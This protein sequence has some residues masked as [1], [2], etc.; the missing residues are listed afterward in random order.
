MKVFVPRILTSL[1]ACMAAIQ[2]AQAQNDPGATPQSGVASVPE[3]TPNPPVFFNDAPGQAAVGN[4]FGYTEVQRVF[5]PL[6]RVDTRGG[7]LFGQTGFT[8]VSGFLPYFLD[9]DSLFF[10]DA[11]GFA[12]YNPSGGANVGFG[13][14]GYLE[15]FDRVVGLV[16]WYDFDAGHQRNYHQFAL[17]FESLG[18]YFD[19]RANGYLP[20]GTTSSTLQSAVAGP[21]FYYNNFILL[22]RLT[23]RET[24]YTG[25]DTEIGG[26]APV[27]GRYGLSAYA[28]FYFFNAGN[29]GSLTG[30]SAR[31]TGQINDSMTVGAQYTYDHVFQSNAQVQVTLTIPDGKPTRWLRQLRVRDRLTAPVIRNYRVVAHEDFIVRAEQAYNPADNQPFFVVHVDPNQNPGVGDGTFENPYSQLSQ[32]DTLA[33]GDKSNVDIVFV[34]PN[35][36]GSSTNLDQGVTLLSNQRLLSSAVPHIFTAIQGT[37]DLPGY[38]P[39]DLPPLLTNAGGGNVVTFADGA[40]NV[41]VSGFTIAGSA[42]GNG[43]FGNNNQGININRNTVQDG[44]NG[45]L[46]TNLSG[47][48]AAGFASIIDQNNFLNNIGDG[49]RVDNDAANP[50]E[51]VLSR[52]NAR[53]N[54]GN[55]FAFRSANGSSIGGI[56]SGNSTA[57]SD[58]TTQNPN[59]NNGLALFADGGTIDFGNLANGWQIGGTDNGSDADPLN[60]ANNFSDN[61]NFGVNVA[62]TN[63]STVSLTL[64]NNDVSRN[65]LNGFGIQADSGTASLIIGGSTAAD[66]NRFENNGLNGILIDLSGSALAA[67]SIQNNT[68]T[69]NGANGLGGGAGSGSSLYNIDVVFNGGLTPSQEA[70][71]ALAAAKWESIIVGDV[72][73]VGSIDDIRI[74]AEGTPIDGAGGILGQAGPT[75]LRPTTFLPYQG[76]MRFDTADL[77]SLEASGQLDEVIVHEMAHVIG[78]GSELIWQP[79]NLLTGAGG[80]DPR[81]IGA[82]AVREYNARFNTNDTGVPVENT[83]GTGTR[84]AHWRESI[85]DN[86]LMTGIL[87][88][89]VPNPISRVTVGQWQDLGY[90]VNYNAAEPYARTGLNSVTVP[91]GDVTRPTPVVGAAVVSTPH[92]NLVAVGAPIGDGIHITTA[93]SAT[94]SPST[95]SNNNVTQSARHGLYVQTADTSAISNLVVNNNQFLNNGTGTIGSG[96]FFQRQDASTFNATVTNNQMSQNLG[97][98]WSINVLGAAAPAMNVASADNTYDANFRHGTNFQADEDGVL[99]FTSSRDVYTG[100]INHFVNLS[101]VGDSVLNATFHNASISGGAN[102]NGTANGV[103]IFGGGTGVLNLTFDSPADPLFTGT[104]TA[105]NNNANGLVA[106]ITQNSKLNLNVFDTSIISNETDGVNIHREDASLVLASFTRTL[107]NGNGDNGLQFRAE[108]ADPS[109]PSQPSPGVPNRLFLTN[110]Q[111]NNNI[112]NGLEVATLVDASLVVNAK[113]TTFNNNGGVGVQ[114]VST[115]SSSFGNVAT[116]ERSVFNGVTIRGNGGDGMQLFAMGNNANK[117][118]IL[119]E[120]NATDGNTDISGNADDGIEATAPY[121]TVDLLVQG[122]TLALGYKTTI[123]RNTGNGIEMNVANIA[124]DGGDTA[125]INAFFPNQFE[126][127]SF[128]RFNGVGVLTVNNVVI[129]D[130]NSTDGIANGNGANG[131]SLFNSNADDFIARVVADFNLTTAP[132]YIAQRAGSLDVTVNNSVVSGNTLDGINFLS[133]G[134]TDAF[135]PGNR[136]NITVTNSH[137]DYN[138]SDGVDMLLNGKNGEYSLLY[139]PFLQTGSLARTEINQFVFDNNTINNNANYGL[140]Y[141]SNAGRMLR[142]NLNFSSAAARTDFWGVE[143]IDPG[144]NPGGG[145]VFNPNA[146]GVTGVPNYNFGFNSDVNLSNFLNLATDINAALVF[147][148]NQV[149]FNGTPSSTTGDGMFLN[150]GTDSYLSADIGGAAGSGNGNTFSG[151]ASADVKFG[152]FTAYERNG[153]ILNPADHIQPP[154]SAPGNVNPGDRIW[155]DD[156]AQLDLRFNNNVG[157]KID[158]KFITVIGPVGSGTAG[159]RAA[160][161][162]NNDVNKGGPFRATQVF[163]VDNGFNLNVNNTWAQDI[164]N[165]LQNNGNFHLRTVADPLFPNPAF[166]ENFATDPGDPFLP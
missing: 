86:E 19:L 99:D 113:L 93:G 76:I 17:S 97:D 28:G 102:N 52:N 75:A 150:I 164:Q 47:T 4:Y 133:Q 131:I 162:D 31:L 151:N 149:K 117:S 50:L 96:A 120:V 156:T 71:F 51:I 100:N 48:A 142:N 9:N 111:L 127:T 135:G 139:N 70:I 158:S 119:V 137:I 107:M 132:F 7:S 115:D 66:G 61:G 38:V 140:H 94:L 124:R 125:I 92:S 34:H 77:A 12:T 157:R 134:V 145:V 72:P 58:P 129:G 118:N 154:A 130:E 40:T 80:S 123:Q 141:E 85:F 112:G 65:S 26:P 95:I 109:D 147:T 32:F 20:V 74:S 110:S 88:A 79:L 153:N 22:N 83:G 116:S 90:Q 63:N 138:G 165:E 35:V 1:L 23:W 121:G 122:D 148:N 67:L 43:I 15:D 2:A 152:S 56:I 166:P 57:L 98:G 8:R 155:L 24:A 159:Q 64:V 14:R 104:G 16:G 68:L 69:A 136:N 73:D 103:N 108:G 81:F 146:I 128:D 27:L 5:E 78:F 30:V 82:N 84:D 101:A 42:T 18:R 163:Q 13:W 44:L 21:A 126:L 37:F 105:I 36:D 161:Y 60:D 55:G 25:F 3:P 53:G 62:S 91:V 33:L 54:E 10:I 29:V 49:F 89:G 6:V 45:V 59:L 46:L 160:V 143:F 41:E 144:V 87:N 39:T 114:V 11:G 106:D